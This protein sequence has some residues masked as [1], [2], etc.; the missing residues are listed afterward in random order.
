MKKIILIGIVIVILI[1]FFAQREKTSKSVSIKESNKTQLSPS[2]TIIQK[3]TVSIFVP[4]WTIGNSKIDDKNF[5][6]LIYF[7]LGVNKNGIDIKDQGYIGLKSFIELSD[8]SKKRLL[9][10][11]MIDSSVNFEIFKD[12]NVSRLIIIDS[13]R[14]AKEN[15]FQGIILN[16]EV[17]SLPFSSVT[18]QINSF[19]ENFSKEAKSQNLEFGITLNGDTFSKIRPFD[20]RFLEKQTD[21]FYIMAYDFSKAKGDPGPNFPLSGHEIYGYDFKIMIT[22]FL[23]L[24]PKEKITV[25]FGMFGY[26]WTVDKDGKSI[27]NAN[28]ISLLEAQHIFIPTCGYRNCVVKRDARSAETNVMYTDSQG[29]NHFVWF[30]DNESVD[31]KKAFLREKGIKSTS[32]WAYSYF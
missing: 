10:I 7:G 19:V 1:I 15:K 31:V 9:A 11:R 6:E 25:V 30:E 2:Q 13:V 22:D 8:L 12:K 21:R 29:N 4:Y 28:S 5:D 32:F 16:L 14:V 23:N 20:V 18:N 24:I 3:D 27:K 26:D 17:A